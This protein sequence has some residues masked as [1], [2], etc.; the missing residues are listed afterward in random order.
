VHNSIRRVGPGSP[1]HREADEALKLK[2]IIK[3][4]E[5]IAPRIRA[6]LQDRAD[7]RDH[8]NIA[9]KGIVQVV[10]VPVKKVVV[11]EPKP[12][13]NVSDLYE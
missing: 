7:I 4:I 3:A 12:T 1:L 10:Q 6:L 11:K 2:A 8:F 13:L 5:Q 9:Y